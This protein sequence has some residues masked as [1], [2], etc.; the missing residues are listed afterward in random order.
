MDVEKVKC[1]VNSGA[2]GKQNRALK[3]GL[4]I[5]IAGRFR[6]GASLLGIKPPRKSYS[7]ACR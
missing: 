4:V 7:F 3:G 5:V 2:T 6:G 1:S